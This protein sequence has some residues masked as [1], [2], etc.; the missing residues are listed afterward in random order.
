M[1]F[2]IYNSVGPVF[3]VSS[4][5]CH[6][7]EEMNTNPYAPVYDPTV[8]GGTADGIDIDYT[9]S[10]NALKSLQATESAV[11]ATFFNFM[12]EGLYNDYQTAT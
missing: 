1:K 6:D 10:E 3:G 9:L 7:V 4:T 12:Y 5:G 2:N 11:G 8:I